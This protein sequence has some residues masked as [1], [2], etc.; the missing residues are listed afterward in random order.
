MIRLNVCSA[1]DDADVESVEVGSE[2]LVYSLLE[3]QHILGGSEVVE[4]RQTGVLQLDDPV[5]HDFLVVLGDLDCSQVC[6][7]PVIARN[8]SVVI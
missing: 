1:S 2:L 5:L 7:S 3:L 6:R 4:G 8:V